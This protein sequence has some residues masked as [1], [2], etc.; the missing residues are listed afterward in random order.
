MSE[1]CGLSARRIAFDGAPVSLSSRLITQN[2]VRLLEHLGDELEILGQVR[3][4]GGQHAVGR[5]DPAKLEVSAVDLVGG[6]ARRHP[7][8]RE[9]VGLLDERKTGGHL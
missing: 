3:G 7:E 9:I 1:T 6:R 4:S 5:K 2:V 8:Q